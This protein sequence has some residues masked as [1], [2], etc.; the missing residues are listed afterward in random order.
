LAEQTL[1]N[2]DGGESEPRELKDLVDHWVQVIDRWVQHIDQGMGGMANGADP[3]AAP[4]LAPE[5][6]SD[7]PALEAG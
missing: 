5:A 7:P 4:D 3:A 2:L 6:G 1:R